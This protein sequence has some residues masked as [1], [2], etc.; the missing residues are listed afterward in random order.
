M[1]NLDEFKK[2]YEEKETAANIH[3]E[4]QRM[5][6]MS[7]KQKQINTIKNMQADIK[8]C[9]D[10]G[11]FLLDH[12]HDLKGQEYGGSFF[13]GERENHLLTDGWFH[14]IGFYKGPN[15]KIIGIGK[16]AGGC[17]GENSLMIDNEGNILTYTEHERC[18]RTKYYGW[19]QE[20]IDEFINGGFEEFKNK[21]QEYA[22][23]SLSAVKPT[24]K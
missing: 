16:Q 14:M 18:C 13:K 8:E 9:I 24:I 1:F 2:V 11:Q 6:K 17:C 3:A 12:G 21:L 19:W 15:N 7:K 10:L 4:M 23:R 5:A 22:L 20:A